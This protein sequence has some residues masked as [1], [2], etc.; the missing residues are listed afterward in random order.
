ML[1]I[2]TGN[3]Q[4]RNLCRELKSGPL[5]W[6]FWKWVSGIVQLLYVAASENWKKLTSEPESGL[7]LLQTTTPQHLFWK[8]PKFILK[9]LSSSCCFDVNISESYSNEGFA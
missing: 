9:A 8:Q 3:E 6:C 2:K 7:L 4:K 1:T 5:Y